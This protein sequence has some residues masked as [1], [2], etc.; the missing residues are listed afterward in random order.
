MI[1]SDSFPDELYRPAKKGAFQCGIIQRKQSKNIACIIIQKTAR[2]QFAAP[3]AYIKRILIAQAV[4]KKTLRPFC[5]VQISGIPTAPVQPAQR[6]DHKGIP[7]RQNLVICMQAGAPPPVFLQCGQKRVKT[8]ICQIFCVEKIGNALTLKVPRFCNT[9]PFTKG[10]A[11]GLPQ[12][13]DDL[14]R[15][16]Y[17]VFSLL[18]IAVRILGAVKAAAGEVISLRI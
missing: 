14:L 15:S 9:E 17:I 13:L 3:N 1:L 18:A 16:E 6:R 4:L 2:P 12:E 11:V 7:C 5:G 8:R 10:G